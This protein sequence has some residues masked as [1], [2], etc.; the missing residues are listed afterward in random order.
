[1]LSEKVIEHVDH[2]QCYSGRPRRLESVQQCTE[3]KLLLR[4]DFDHA[5][6]AKC[7]MRGELLKPGQLFWL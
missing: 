5:A 6:D 2:K 3:L 4:I 7:A 1:M